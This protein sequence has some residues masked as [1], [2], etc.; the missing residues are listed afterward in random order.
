MGQRL[1]SPKTMYTKRQKRFSAYFHVILDR[2]FSVSSST[3]CFTQWGEIISVKGQNNFWQQNAF[4]TC[5]NKLLKFKL[6]KKYWDLEKCRKSWKKCFANV[7]LRSFKNM[8]QQRN[9]F[10]NS[11]EIFLSKN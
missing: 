11:N 2:L 6:E 3:L 1:Y 4:L 8:F 7:L 9:V 5:S 10:L